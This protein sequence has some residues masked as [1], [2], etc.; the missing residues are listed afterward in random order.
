MNHGFTVRACPESI[1]KTVCTA[2][3]TDAKHAC[4]REKHVIHL[5][6]IEPVCLEQDCRLTIIPKI[7]QHPQVGDFLVQDQQSKRFIILAPLGIEIVC[8]AP[9]GRL[10]GAKVPHVHL[11]YVLVG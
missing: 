8:G 9:F 10:F 6:P 3:S 11:V 2:I 7:L 4:G 5:Q 1:V